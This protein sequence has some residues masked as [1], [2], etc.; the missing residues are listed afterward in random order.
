MGQFGEGVGTTASGDT[1]FVPGGLPGDILEVS[2]K[3]KLSRKYFLGTLDSVV[4]P[5]PERVDPQCAFFQ[6]CGGCDWLHWD[7][8]RQVEA[9]KKILEHALGRAGLSSIDPVEMIPASTTRGYRTRIQVRARDHAMG[10]FKRHTRDLV[11]V[12]TC[13]LVVPEIQKAYASFRET[14]LPVAEPTKFE[15]SLERDGKVSV[16]TN[17]AHS[18]SGFRQIHEEQNARLKEIVSDWVRQAGSKKVLELYCGN[19]NLTEAYAPLVD[20][21]LAVEGNASAIAQAPKLSQVEYQTAWVDGHLLEKLPP[22]V[23]NLYD[24][25]LL[26]PPRTG[27]GGALSYF[28]HARL[29]CVIYVSCSVESFS[30]DSRALSK[31]FLLQKVWGIDMFPQTRHFELVSFWQRR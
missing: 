7:Y 3:K 22:N 11:D 20:S 30:S 27:V 31:A 24:T 18:A 6:R 28:I 13:A 14:A 17:S 23:R 25:L 5:S 29:H 21:V 1:Y 16:A 19:G 9:K 12:S 8:P 10:F 2:L 15:F 4:T 26:D